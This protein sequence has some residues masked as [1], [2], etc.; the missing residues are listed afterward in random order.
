MDPSRSPDDPSR[1]NGGA[2]L[3][4]PA[5]LAVWVVV[6][7]LGWLVVAALVVT[8]GTGDVDQIADEQKLDD[9]ELAPA[10]GPDD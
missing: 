2:R 6:S 9:V 3:R 7:V 5:A 10:S 4:W 8:L 1:R